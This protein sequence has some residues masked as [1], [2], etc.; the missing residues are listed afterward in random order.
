MGFRVM[1]GGIIWCMLRS[2][3]LPHREALADDSKIQLGL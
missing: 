2:V 1:C 3:E